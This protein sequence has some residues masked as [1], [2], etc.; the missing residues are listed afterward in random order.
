MGL[1]SNVNYVSW[2]YKKC[3]YNKENILYGRVSMGRERYTYGGSD[4]HVS[5]KGFDI[6]K[7]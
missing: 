3:A 1:L 4:L 6:R 7:R 2:D 5:K